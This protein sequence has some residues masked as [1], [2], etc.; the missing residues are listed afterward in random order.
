MK[1]L[2]PVFC[3]PM[4]YFIIALALFL[5]FILVMMGRVTDANLL[6]YK[7][8][9]KLLMMMGALMIIFALTKGESKEIEQVRNK[10]VRNAIF[11]TVLFVFGGMLW[12]VAKGDLMS[13]D[14]SSFLI[15]LILNVLCLEYGVKKMT[16]DRIFKK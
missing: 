8:C 12:R 11:L 4:G 13:V 1:A 2:L 6:F 9:S 7:E 15:F 16:V 3:R 14:T 5:P 10:A